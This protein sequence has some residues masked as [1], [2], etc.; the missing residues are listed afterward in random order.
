MQGIP[1]LY[2]LFKLTYTV[3]T[4]VA[5]YTPD[6][7]LPNFIII[8]AK[9]WLTL[10]D[11]KKMVWVKQALPDLDIR[12]V[13]GNSR[14]PIR[15][16][17]KTTYAKWCDANGFPHADRVVPKAW[18]QEAPKKIPQSIKDTVDDSI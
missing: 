17:S 18:L 13:F 10:E 8:E 6:F 9:G 2:E 3:P 12:F 1:V 5:T 15:K 11:R 14:K 16:G 7:I 4:R